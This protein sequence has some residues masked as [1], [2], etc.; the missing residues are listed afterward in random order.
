MSS[1]SA[2]NLFNVKEMVFVVTGAGSGNPPPSRTL[3]LMHPADQGPP[4]TGLG[5]MMS[6]ALDANGA[7]KV[8]ALGRRLDKLEEA[9]KSAVCKSA[10][11]PNAQFFRSSSMLTLLNP[12]PM[13][14]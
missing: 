2:Q 4:S 10:P 6:K 14:P 12:R 9:A 5:L 3:C 11:R 13:A 8:Y 7:A 1:T